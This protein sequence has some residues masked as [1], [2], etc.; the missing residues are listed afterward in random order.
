MRSRADRDFLT[1]LRAGAPTVLLEIDG[2]PVAVPEGTSVL[3]AADEAGIHIPKLCATDSLEPFGSCRL[4]L[5]E[6]EGQ[7]GYPASCTTPARAGMFFWA[8]CARAC[9]PTFPPAALIKILLFP[10]VMVI[11]PDT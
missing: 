1:P 10:F 2:R 9:C 5:I 3:R 7:R 11:S 8:S 4:C 6:V